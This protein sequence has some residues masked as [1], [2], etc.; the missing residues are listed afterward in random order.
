MSWRYQNK[1]KKNYQY[2]NKFDKVWK[3]GNN[4]YQKK[5]NNKYNQYNQYSNYNN[6]NDYYNYNNYSNEY[7]NYNNNYYNYNNYNS[8][9]N[10]YNNYNYYQKGRYPFRKYYREI[11]VGAKNEIDEKFVEEL[12]KIGYF[13]REVKGD[14]NCLFRSVSEQI[15]ENENNYEEYRKKCVEYM[16]ENKDT[17]IPFLEEDEPFDTY[18][19]KIA[20]NGEWGGNLEIYALSMALKSNFYIYIHEQPIYVVKNWE[21]PEKNIMLTYHN[22]KHYNSL[23]KLEE[24]TDE[25]KEKEIKKEENKKD[26]KN[27]KEENENNNDQNE[28]GK[29][30]NKDNK[31]KNENGKKESEDHKEKESQDNKEKDGVVGEE[32]DKK[33]KEEKAKKKDDINDLMNKVKHLNI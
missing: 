9:Y 2:T 25:D 21:E 30:E 11:E 15:E 26:N 7:N 12:K 19:E 16:K 33:G 18:I 3:E 17:F 23:R 4:Y 22:G 6:D 28:N 20:K 31:D 13:I 1:N 5:Y 14:G 32:A 10:Y 29:E 8:Y 24:K 27:E